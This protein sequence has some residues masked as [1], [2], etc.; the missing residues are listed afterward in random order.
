MDTI[1]SIEIKKEDEK[2]KNLKKTIRKGIEWTRKN[3]YRKQ[4]NKFQICIIRMSREG[5][6]K[7]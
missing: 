1:E 2:E 7:Q 4:V 6:T 3:K 5:K